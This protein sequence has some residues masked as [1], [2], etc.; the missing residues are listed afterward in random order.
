M[1]L[2]VLILGL[3]VLPSLAY[4]QTEQPAY[5]LN[6]GD[7]ILVSVWGQAELT[8]DHVI[9][10]DG[11]VSLPLV[12]RLLAAGLTTVQLEDSLTEALRNV[13]REP[14]VTVSVTSVAGN[15]VFVIGKVASPGI[16]TMI[17]PMTISQVLSQVGGV[18]TFAD[19]DRISVLRSSNTGRERLRF[20][21]D[22]YLDND[23]R[24]VDHLL[25]AGDIVVVP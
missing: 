1:R 14:D 22:R 10:P 20:N 9:L 6:P 19:P 18:S 5:L 17:A 11:S 8:G 25:K 3:L 4:A 15:R 7:Q 2:I 21:L 23:E 13:L 16:V 24:V 12:G